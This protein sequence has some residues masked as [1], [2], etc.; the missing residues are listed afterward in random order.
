MLY[1]TLPIIQ[2]PKR[3][4]SEPQ[5]I[6]VPE[7]DRFIDSVTRQ[8]V[9]W[10]NLDLGEPKLDRRNARYVVPFWLDMNQGNRIY[11]IQSSET[12]ENKT[13]LELGN[14]FV[15]PE[16]LEDLDQRRA[17]SYKKL[18]ALGMIEISDGLLVTLPEGLSHS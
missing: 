13:D 15:L 10:I 7:K 3:Q 11:H 16:P 2:F 5:A 1:R 17:Y 6:I 12:S 9:V 18:F 8:G 4:M 14:S